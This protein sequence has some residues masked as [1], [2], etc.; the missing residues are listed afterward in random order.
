[1]SETYSVIFEV[2]G[3]VRP[4]VRQLVGENA[5]ADAILFAAK[6]EGARI[7]RDSDNAYRDK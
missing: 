5:E 2:T 4:H 3:S 6:H 7:R 1:M